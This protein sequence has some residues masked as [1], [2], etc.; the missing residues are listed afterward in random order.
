MALSLTKGQKLSLDKV[1]PGLVHVTV[2]LGWRSRVT[3]GEKFD[4]D[5]SSFGLDRID[6]DAKLIDDTWFI[7]YGQTVS[8]D[9]S[10]SHSPDDTEGA[11]DDAAGD[12]ETIDVDLSKV[13]GNVA[14]IIFTATIYEF[15]KRGQTFGQ[16]SNAYIRLVN[17]VT[18][19]EVL[20]YD[21][22]ED[23]S[24]ET[25]VEFGALYRGPDG[26]W[27]FNAIGDGYDGG[28][29]QMCARYGLDI[30]EEQ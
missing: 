10:V 3:T 12:Q 19:E 5:A 9:G 22:G 23:Y 15:R 16:V 8:P 20:R 13:S 1:A 11:E 21:L 2:G 24:T 7:F 18:G 26:S 14:K 6:D 28:L 30:P 17:S 4:L 25:A 27:K 29:S